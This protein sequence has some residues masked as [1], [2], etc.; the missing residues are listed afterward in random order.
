MTFTVVIYE[1]EKLLL[2]QYSGPTPPLATCRRIYRVN[3]RVKTRHQECHRSRSSRVPH[4]QPGSRLCEGCSTDANT[5]RCSFRCW[6][7]PPH[8]VLNPGLPVSFSRSGN[9]RLSP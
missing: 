1:I 2:C 8:P 9:S 5:P 6:Q 7:A 4:T 3:G